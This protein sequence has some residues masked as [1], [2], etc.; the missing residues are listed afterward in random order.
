M[1]SGWDESAK[2]WITDIGDEGDFGRKY[3]LDKP[4]LERVTGKGFATALDVGCGEGRF[5]RMLRERGVAPIGIDPTEALL[6]VARA[7][8]PE[9][10]Y[11]AGRAE[12]LEFADA[13]FDLVVSYLTL[14]DIPDIDAA[15]PEMERVLK[16][17]GTLLVANLTSFNTASQPF[18]WKTGPDGQKYF[19][20]DH[21]MTDRA[22]WMQWRGIHIHNWHR[23]L[24]RYMT[25]FL[26]EGLELKSFLEPM[27]SADADPA[28]SERHHRVPYFV[29]M[30]WR[31]PA[32]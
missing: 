5:C 32:A 1:S 15:I 4:M 7:R 19:A 27:P 30:E 26:G 23:P 14:I 2:A 8:D 10:D 21:Y 28:A 11:R 16:P 3:V 18:G 20:I 12:E 24:S 9:G 25:L 31:K 22:D 17:G 6:A 29:L 13:S